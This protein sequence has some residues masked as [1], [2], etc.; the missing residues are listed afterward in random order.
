MKP[1][2]YGFIIEFL[3]LQDITDDFYHLAEKK[4]LY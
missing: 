2:L 3:S 1:L 4:G